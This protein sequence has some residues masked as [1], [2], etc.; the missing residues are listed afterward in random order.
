VAGKVAT[1]APVLR[2]EAPASAD[3][4]ALPDA[5]SGCLDDAL[6]VAGEHFAA[7][8]RREYG[9]RAAEVLGERL[10]ADLPRLA[11]LRE[12]TATA[13]MHGD[14]VSYLLAWHRAAARLDESVFRATWV[15]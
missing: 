12:T 10:D 14:L 4:A 1:A 15:T 7:G 8:S 5:G 9:P 13:A 6:A 2:V 11:C 3:D